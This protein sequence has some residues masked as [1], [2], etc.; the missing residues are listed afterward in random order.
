MVTGRPSPQLASLP[1]PRGARVYAH[2]DDETFVLGGVLG[3]LVD[4]GTAVG[5]LC[6]SRG[7]AS[8]LGGR[9]DDLGAV[10][11]AE[12]AAAARVLGLRRCERSPTPTAGS[13]TR[14]SLT[15]RPVWSESLCARG[16]SCSWCSTTAA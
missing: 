15:S 6:F 4:A 1:G 3:A 12:L 16:P 2:P 9:P 11:A 8:I 13:P 14:R 7:E 10:R 5:G